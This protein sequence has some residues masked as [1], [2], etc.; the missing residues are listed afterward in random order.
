MSP[1]YRPQ[2]DLEPRAP[3]SSFIYLPLMFFL[4]SLLYSNN[5]LD[6]LCTALRIILYVASKPSSLSSHG[7]TSHFYLQT[8]KVDIFYIIDRL[9]FSKPMFKHS[10]T[11]TEPENAFTCNKMNSTAI[12]AMY[13]SFKF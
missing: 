8:V 13:I 11:G 6:R 2:G 1:T 10:Y 3:T 12:L 5:Q 9:P 4:I 7:R